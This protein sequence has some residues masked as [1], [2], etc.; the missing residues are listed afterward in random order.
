MANTG[1]VP[2]TGAFALDLHQSDASPRADGRQSVRVK[3]GHVIGR[4]PN[5]IW[6]PVA[7]ADVALVDN[8]T[9]YIEISAAGAIVSNQ[10]GFT[11]GAQQI[12]AITVAGGNVTAIADWRFR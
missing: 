10:S 9:T 4:T 12:Y 6:A 3:G 2:D 11:G 5:A 8:A 1:V 7:A